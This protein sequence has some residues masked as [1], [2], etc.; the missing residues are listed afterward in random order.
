[1]TPE[2]R[3]PY[4][5]LCRYRTLFLR[6]DPSRFARMLPQ[7]EA[8]QFKEKYHDVDGRVT[9]EMLAEQL[10]GRESYAVPLRARTR[11]ILFWVYSRGAVR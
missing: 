8:E 9:D 10:S 2:R 3:P 1:M 11:N 4:Q 5:L 7:E 6:H